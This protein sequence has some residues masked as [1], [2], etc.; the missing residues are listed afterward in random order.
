MKNVENWSFSVDN[1]EEE[2]FEH[3]G[4]F[5]P[6]ENFGVKDDLRRRRKKRKFQIVSLLKK[7]NSKCVLAN[8]C[9]LKLCP[10]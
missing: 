6:K 2:G 10:C 1:C 7:F 8:F 5:E 3:F 4:E 9:E